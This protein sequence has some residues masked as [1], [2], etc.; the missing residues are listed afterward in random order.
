[1]EGGCSSP[2]LHHSSRALNSALKNKA[3]SIIKLLTITVMY[4]S[5]YITIRYIYSYLTNISAGGTNE[6]TLMQPTVLH[7]PYNNLLSSMI[8]SIRIIA[9]LRKKI[10][11]SFNLFDIWLYYENSYKC[12]F[13]K[14]ML[15]I[16]RNLP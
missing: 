5:P 11:S 15:Y 8:T 2:G 10:K 9:N 6:S 3:N 13:E 1:M 4:C 16:I 7:N 14:L 12:S